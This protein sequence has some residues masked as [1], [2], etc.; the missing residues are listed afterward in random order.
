M[1]HY[2]ITF[3]DSDG[4]TV[5]TTKTVA[6]GSVPSYTPTK[7]GYDHGGWTPTPVAVTGN[8]SYTA[9]WVEKPTFAT[10]TWAKI[11]EVCAAGNHAST[12]SV[13][14]KKPV[15]LTYEDGTS[16]TINFTIVDMDVDSI[17]STKKAPLTLMADNIVA[18][19]PTKLA[20]K[21]NN[22][23]NYPYRM[24][25]ATTFLN[26]V[27]SA[28]PADLQSVIKPCMY[29]TGLSWSTK[30]F[31]PHTVNLGLSTA[32]EHTG[33]TVSYNGKY[34]YFANGVSVK[35]TKLTEE[36]MDNY[37]TANC[38]KSVSSG[39]YTSYYYAVVDGTSVMSERQSP[40]DKTH[41]IVPCFC[42]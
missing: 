42:I 33:E 39:S 30:I 18:I 6:Y 28:L 10:A 5:L 26:K 15:T 32:D 14:D 3:Y 27:F 1:R 36:S 41:G 7:E 31:I 24:D 22:H 17:S 19:S 35:R 9:V 29:Y 37:W 16:E 4:T 20:S 12:F 25:T 34:K 11:A 8:A 13:G 21:Y 23:S 40:S 38:T 2:T